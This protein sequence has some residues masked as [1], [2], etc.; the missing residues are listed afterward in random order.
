MPQSCLLRDIPQDPRHKVDVAPLLPPRAEARV[1]ASTEDARHR[2]HLC[3]VEPD[4]DPPPVAGRDQLQGLAHVD[5]VAD[6]A[7]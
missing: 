7:T 6:S 4:I 2:L 5:A 1:E 3:A